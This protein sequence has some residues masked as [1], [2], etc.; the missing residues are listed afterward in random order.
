MHDNIKDIKFAPKII[1]LA[2]AVAMA[3]GEIRIY[4]PV[5]LNELGDWQESFSGIKT[6]SMGS[7][8]CNCVEW[9]TAFDEPPM[10]AVG[11]DQ[12]QKSKQDQQQ[13]SSLIHLYKLEQKDK[14]GVRNAD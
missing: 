5:Q 12:I 13:H 11:C 7:T 9:G 8:G 2:F 4:S 3:V 14:K 1:G 10:L 6:N